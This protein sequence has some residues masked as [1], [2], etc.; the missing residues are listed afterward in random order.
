VQVVPEDDE[1]DV[2]HCRVPLDRDL[3][4]ALDNLRHITLAHVCN[5]PRARVFRTLLRLVLT[6]QRSIDDLVKDQQKA[7]KVKLKRKR[8][9]SQAIAIRD[10]EIELGQLFLQALLRHVQEAAT[11]L[12]PD[13]KRE[14]GAET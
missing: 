13:P 5:V 6:A 10:H 1:D 2:P 11:T 12:P 14:R 9:V 7:W 8:Q 3:S 4:R